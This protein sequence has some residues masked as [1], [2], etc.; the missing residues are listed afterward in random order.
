MGIV[1]VPVLPTQDFATAPNFALMVWDRDSGLP[2]RQIGLHMNLFPGHRTTLSADLRQEKVL[3]F[4]A[5][6]DIAMISVT[7]R[8]GQDLLQYACERAT[9]QLS[10][11]LAKSLGLSPGAAETKEERLLN[12]LMALWPTNTKATGRPEICP[13]N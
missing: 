10:P 8:R 3:A 12:R 2:L 11:E 6:G 13:P 9:R 7:V 5:D 1:P 4:D